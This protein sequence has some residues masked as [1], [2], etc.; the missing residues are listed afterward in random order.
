MHKVG[1][2]QSIRDRITERRGRRH[3]WSD[4]T[5]K[6]TAL[7][8]IDMQNHFIDLI[9]ECRGITP[10]INRI[11]DALRHSGGIV[12]WIQ[13]THTGEGRSAWPMFFE[14]F[15]SPELGA[16]IRQKLSPGAYGHALYDELDVR[17]ED[18]IVPKDRFSALIQGASDLEGQLRS[19]DIDTVIITG[20]NTNVCCEST[21]RDAMMLDFKT[22]LV[23][24]ANAAFSDEEHVAG[25]ITV[26]QNF[27]DVVTTDEI[28]ELID[29]TSPRESVAAG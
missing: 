17:D 2:P 8:V 3:V 9:D 18:L 20:T 14:H 15:V 22:F 16:E 12:V 25:L 21:A 26:A 28:I 5:A 24:D 4:L 10:N 7:V 13:A 29:A 27:A 19:R 6:N 1:L 23:E 11:A